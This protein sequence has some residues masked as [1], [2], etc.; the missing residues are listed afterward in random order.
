MRISYSVVFY[1][2]PQAQI[3]A[4][5]D[6]LTAAT[7]KEFSYHIYFINNSPE[8]QAVSDA[9][10]ALAAGDANITAVV[11][12]TNRGFGAGHN[13]V[14]DGLD[15]NYHFI[16][17]PDILVPDADQIRLMID[18]MEK[19]HIVLLNP[20]IEDA[21]GVLQKLV[22]REPTVLDLAL[23][24]MGPKV[25]PKRQAWFVYDGQYDA[26]HEV[27][28]VSGSF[29]V[30]QTAALKQ[31]RGFDERY[32]LY[33]ED[34]DLCRKL[35]SVGRVVYLPTARVV[36]EWQRA[37]RNS[38]RGIGRMLHSMGQYFNKWGWRMW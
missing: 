15:S 11:A 13:L 33:M 16:V 18:Q 23:R 22:K 19:D 38:L 4:L 10:C 14:I 9:M 31:V 30:C 7:P 5:Y 8:N 29:M 34:T 3:T 17:N 32:F 36:H 26:T 25:M 37:N 6:N 24:F 1:N 12:E 21:A 27:Q 2:P 20:R 35:G 28:V